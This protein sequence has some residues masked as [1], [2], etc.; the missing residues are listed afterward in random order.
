M[1]VGRFRCKSAPISLLFLGVGGKRLLRSECS[2]SRD[3]GNAPTV[4]MTMIPYEPYKVVPRVINWPRTYE[5][6]P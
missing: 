1:P 4:I 2:T 3:T 5:H 6:R